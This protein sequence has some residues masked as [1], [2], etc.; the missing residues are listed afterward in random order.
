MPKSIYSPD[1][2]LLQALLKKT[3][4]Q[5]GLTQLDLA[6]KLRKP[7]SHVSKFESGER[8]LDLIELQRVCRALDI[9]LSEFVAA[10]ERSERTNDAR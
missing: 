4:L 9:R 10:F 1:Q 7:Q 5:S 3:R 2:L 6:K 8:R